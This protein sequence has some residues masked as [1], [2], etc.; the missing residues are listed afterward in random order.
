MKRVL[1]QLSVALFV[2]ASGATAE[3]AVAGTAPL[4]SQDRLLRFNKRI[5]DFEASRDTAAI[6]TCAFGDSVTQG[7][8]ENEKL[9]HRN[10]YHAQVSDALRAAHPRGVF[11]TLN[12]GI[13]GQTIEGS[14]KR[15]DRDVI[16]HQPDLVFIGFGLND[17]SKGLEGVAAFKENL[18]LCV[19]KITQNTEAAI[20]LLTPNMMCFAETD[21]IPE[22]WQK[23]FPTLRDRQVSGVLA[24]YVEAIRRVGLETDTLVA[25]VYAEWERKRTLGEDT[26]QLLANGLNHPTR[27]GHRLTADLILKV[28]KAQ[29]PDSP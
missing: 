21:R 17:S 2:C 11:N 14:L 9:D 24:V 4:T 29:N 18:R 22:R 8:M 23:A 1:L 12:A 27:E 28:L 16:R 26:D 25:D 3:E 13:G 5:S 6:L 20:I 19:E 10:V 15:L 7:W